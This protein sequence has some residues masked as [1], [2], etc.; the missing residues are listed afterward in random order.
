MRTRLMRAQVLTIVALGAM[1]ATTARAQTSTRRAK[2]TS[3]IPVT[4]EPVTPDSSVTR[5]SVTAV[6]PTPPP[7]QPAAVYTEPTPA[8]VYSAP[9]SPRLRMKRY[10][11]GGYVG[12]AGGAGIPTGVIRN[13][14]DAGVGVAVP[15]GWDAALNPWGFRI[16]LGYQR[17]GARSTFRDPF[18]AFPGAFPALQSAQIYSAMADA[19][20]RIPFS[21]SWTGPTTGLYLLA[22][23]GLNHFRHYDATFGLTNPE[24]ESSTVP[25][26]ERSLTRFAVNAGG[27]VYYG[28]RATEVFLESRYVTTYMP[29]GRV[30][31]VPIVLGVNL[32]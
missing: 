14:Y 3:R 32:Y 18:T 1:L 7:A 25:T 5:D 19:K 24:F 9:A 6:N 8:P 10:G 17:L 31:Y 21:T 22:G 2:S 11:N 20:Y 30:S 29:E 15:I 28:F 26:G 27:G 4:K 23:G 13:G 16:D 12:V